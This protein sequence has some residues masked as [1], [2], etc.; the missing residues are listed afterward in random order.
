MRRRIAVLTEFNSPLEI[1]EEEIAPLAEG[2]VLVELAASGV[3]G[4]DVHMWKGKDPRTPLPL[5]L[6]HEGVGTVVDVGAGK[7]DIFGNTIC[8]GDLIIWDRGVT[9]NHCYFCAVLKEPS[10]CP[11]RQ[12]YGVVRN[13]C[14]ATHLTLLPKT[15]VLKLAD[16]EE[17]MDPAILVAAA[18]S[19][20]TA[21]HTVEMLPIRPGD[22]VIVQGP[23]PLGLFCLAFAFAKGASRAIVFGTRADTSRLELSKEFGSVVTYVVED[24]S[25][26]ARRAEVMDL[27]KGIGAN[28][29]IDCTGTPLSFNEGLRLTAPG[30]TY[31]LPG[32]ATPVGEVPI[33]I[34]E[35]V[36]RKNVRIQGVWVSDTS[37]LYQAVQLVLDGRFPLDKLV[38]HRFPLDKV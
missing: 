26:E 18:C 16:D 10:L 23:G 14:Y 7:D 29:V 20:A 38:T 33:S 30:G 27:T 19:G 2:E 6:G 17:M 34:Y 5:V 35:D 37:H 13:G 28:V 32:T 36:A 8:E 31:A 21:A 11:N 25:A 22:T 1:R 4:S 3:C 9:C 15:K 24:S 12:V